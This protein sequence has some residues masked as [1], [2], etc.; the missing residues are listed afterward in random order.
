MLDVAASMTCI[1]NIVSLV[2][3]LFYLAMASFFRMPSYFHFRPLY[4]KEI[5]LKEIREIIFDV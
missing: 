1:L 3:R 4:V 2:K 5:A